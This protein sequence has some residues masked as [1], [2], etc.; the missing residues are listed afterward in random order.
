MAKP[1]AAPAKPHRREIDRALVAEL[2]EH[3]DEAT[4]NLGTL[5]AVIGRVELT[6]QLLTAW[7]KLGKHLHAT[8]KAGPKECAQYAARLDEI[9]EAMQEY[10]AFLGQ[11][12]K[13]GYRVLVLARLKMPLPTARAMTE[14]QRADLL[15]DWQV[16]RQVL[17]A[18][19]KYLRIK[20]Q[21][22]RHRTKLGLILHALRSVLNDSPWLTLLGALVLAGLIVAAAA[23]LFW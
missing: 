19:R 12:G 6:R 5:D 3:S 2:A 4:S 18:H 8:K 1:F 17:L 15:F 23:K 14:D 9:A 13:P 21:A 16:G 10:P 20:F 7:D 11:P 22:L